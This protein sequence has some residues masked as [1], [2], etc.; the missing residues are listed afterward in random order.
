MKIT[1]LYKNL[2]ISGYNCAIKDTYGFLKYVCSSSKTETKFKCAY[3]DEYY[4]YN[5]DPVSF[6]GEI[7][8]N[9]SHYYQACD[10]RIGEKITNNDL[11]CEQF[12]C[13]RADLKNTLYTKSGLVRYGICKYQ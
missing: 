10:K 12:I 7:C 5:I 3:S 11:L 13:V 4:S 1:V 8:S 9:D 2:K 6:P